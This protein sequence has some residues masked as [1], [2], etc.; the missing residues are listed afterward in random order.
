MLSMV[1]FCR[2]IAFKFLLV[3]FGYFC[4]SFLC[5]RRQIQKKQCYD[6]RQRVPC[7]S[8]L[9]GILWFHASHLGI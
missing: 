6:L 1:F 5:L 8:S 9:L 7:L 2:E 3:P 4:F